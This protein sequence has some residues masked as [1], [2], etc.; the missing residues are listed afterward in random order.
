MHI[1]ILA[2]EAQPFIV[3]ACDQTLPSNHAF[4]L[5]HM[6]YGELFKNS[7]WQAQAS[8]ES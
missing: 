3:S 6:S 7:G 2:S 8:P 5:L 4:E 1:S